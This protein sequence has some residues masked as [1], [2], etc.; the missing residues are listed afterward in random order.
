M[1]L[2]QT[3]KL[4]VTVVPQELAVAARRVR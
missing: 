1:L 3:E 4:F 2:R